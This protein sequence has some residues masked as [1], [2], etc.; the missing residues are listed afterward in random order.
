MSN[1]FH[2]ESPVKSKVSALASVGTVMLMGMLVRDCRTLVR[3][4]GSCSSDC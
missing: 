1:S 3:L 4:M 2:Q